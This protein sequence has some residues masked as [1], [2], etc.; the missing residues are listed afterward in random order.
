[1]LVARPSKRTRS[2][3]AG[4]DS[5]FDILA[6]DQV[7]GRLSSDRKTL[8]AAF[9]LDSQAFVVEHTRG[10]D[11]YALKDAEG[12][13]LALADQTGEVFQVSR[14]EERF[15]FAKG[16]SRL[17]F[18]LKAE[19]GRKP[20]GAVGQR[21]FWTLKMHMDLPDALG[22][23]FQVFLLHLLLVLIAQRAGQLTNI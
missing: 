5:R 16:R 3:L 13:V 19:G 18:D 8:G 20:L 15:R 12:R 4:S 17:L 7:V 6:G 22:A 23:P 10:P 9:S 14:G 21:G 1:M 11:R 2:E